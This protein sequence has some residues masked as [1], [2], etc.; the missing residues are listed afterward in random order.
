MDLYEKNDRKCQ[1]VLDII[2]YTWKN[3]VWVRQM[4]KLHIDYPELTEQQII[5]DLIYKEYYSR[6]ECNLDR[7][8]REVRKIVKIKDWNKWGNDGQNNHNRD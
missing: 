4:Y 6:E 2:F 5:N 3:E 8:D 1:K 7:I